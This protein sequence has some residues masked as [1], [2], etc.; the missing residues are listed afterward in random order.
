MRRVVVVSVAVVLIMFFAGADASY[1]ASA[2]WRIVGLYVP[3]SASGSPSLPAL[4]MPDT[5][6]GIAT[7]GHFYGAA[8]LMYKHNYYVGSAQPRFEDSG[9]YLYMGTTSLALGLD[10]SPVWADSITYCDD[11]YSGCTGYLDIPDTLT[12]SGVRLFGS[13]LAWVYNTQAGKQNEV[14]SAYIDVFPEAALLTCTV[15]VPSTAEFMDTIPVN[16]SCQGIDQGWDF[17]YGVPAIT[18][19]YYAWDGKT[20]WRKKPYNG[21]T[22]YLGGDDYKDDEGNYIEYGHLIVA[23][24]VDQLVCKSHNR[25][26][27]KWNTSRY[28]GWILRDVWVGD[29]WNVSTQLSGGVVQMPE[30]GYVDV[31]YQ[32]GWYPVGVPV[33]LGYSCNWIELPAFLHTKGK[34]GCEVEGIPNRE[35][36]YGWKLQVTASN[37]ESMMYDGMIKI[38]R[39]EDVVSVPGGSGLTSWVIGLTNTANTGIGSIVMSLDHSRVV[40]TNALKGLNVQVDDSLSSFDTSKISDFVAYGKGLLPPGAGLP[41]AAWIAVTGIDV[42]LAFIG[43]VKGVIKW[44]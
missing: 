12:A 32:G 22:I 23:I 44:W 10:E 14:A 13:Y 39:F 43:V 7:S 17:P 40:F 2:P 6:W 3:G 18:N 24:E 29:F 30:T 42:A 21:G 4:G 27:T 36:L 8:A 11:M 19:L 25:A 28:Y 26:C 38:N 37:G 16:S 5:E 31:L 41:I 33:S 1:A 34:G 35:G 15:I 9:T 20:G